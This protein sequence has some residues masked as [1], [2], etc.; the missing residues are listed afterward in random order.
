M[1]IGIDARFFGSVCKGLGR[2]TEKLIQNLEKISAQGGPASPSLGGPASPSLGG[3]TSGWDDQYFIFLSQEGFKQYQPQAKNFQKVLA[4]YQWYSLE[5]QL[6]MPPLLNKYQLD[7]V[8]FPHFNVPIFYRKKFIVTIHDL[9][10][11]HFPT[12]RGT[13]LDSFLYWFKFLMYKVVIYW[14]IKRSEKI[15]TVSEFTKKDLLENYSIN[16]QKIEVTYEAGE[17][18]C[19][20]LPEKENQILKKYAIIKPYLLYV[21]NAYPHKNLEKLVSAFCE[22]RKKIANIHLVLVGKEDYFFK[23]LKAKIAQKK[24]GAGIIFTGFISDVELDV[25]YKNALVYVFPSLYEGFG[26]PPLEAMAKGVPVASSDHPCMQEIL[27]ES[28][29]YFK[30]QDAKEMAEKLTEIIHNPGLR[31]RLIQKGYAQIK[32]YSWQLM[33]EKTRSIYQNNGF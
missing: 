21:G 4:D 8:H 23:K 28:A 19:N 26:L 13:T 12:L 17:G 33:A 32:K 29:F 3:P 7:L 6:K 27:G 2:Y 5:E 14:A 25:F 9:I 24:P 18:F 11:L 10:L 15:I 1:R 16:P 22:I 31:E 30:A 20:W